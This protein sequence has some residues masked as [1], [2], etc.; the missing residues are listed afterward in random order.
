MMSQ[1][2]KPP[3]CRVTMQSS[4]WGHIRADHSIGK[5]MNTKRRPHHRQVP[6]NLLNLLPADVPCAMKPHVCL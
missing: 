5:E 3:A 6:H 2:S 4:V 1:R